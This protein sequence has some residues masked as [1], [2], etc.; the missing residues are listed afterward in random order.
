MRFQRGLT[1][2]STGPAF[3]RPEHGNV[4]QLATDPLNRKVVNDK[5]GFIA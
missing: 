5:D 1:R 2:Y 4:G 3:G